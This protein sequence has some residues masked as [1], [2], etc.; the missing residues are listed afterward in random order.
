MQHVVVAHLKPGGLQST[1]LTSLNYY[2]L[3]SLQVTPFSY[4]RTYTVGMNTALS[5]IIRGSH[6]FG[7]G[8]KFSSCNMVETLMTFLTISPIDENPTCDIQF[9]FEKTKSN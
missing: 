5:Q 3:L 8:F 2:T 6:Q 4:N 9:E 7:H 1:F